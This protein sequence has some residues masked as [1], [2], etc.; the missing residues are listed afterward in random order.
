MKT[1][2]M[3]SILTTKIETEAT[4]VS[5]NSNPMPSTSMVPMLATK[6]KPGAIFENVLP[7]IFTY[8]Y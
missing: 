3:A 4:A 2:S 1:T 8:I 6:I 5:Y 7:V